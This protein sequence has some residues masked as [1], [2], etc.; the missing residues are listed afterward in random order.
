MNMLKHNCLRM[1]QDIQNYKNNPQE[2]ML[3]YMKKRLDKSLDTYYIEM[4]ESLE[5]LSRRKDPTKI[6]RKINK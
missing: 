4:S 2:L 1:L 5:Y 6:I 3:Q